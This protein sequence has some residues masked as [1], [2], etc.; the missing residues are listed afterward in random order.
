MVDFTS[1]FTK[2]L[3]SQIQI[4]TQG[5]AE[6]RS[7]EEQNEYAALLFTYFTSPRTLIQHAQLGAVNLKNY[8]KKRWA[9]EEGPTIPPETKNYIKTYIYNS[10]L[11]TSAAVSAQLQESIE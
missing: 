2:C 4:R 11:N 1:I 5:E 9:P 7:L 6:L 10:M 8:I 3:S